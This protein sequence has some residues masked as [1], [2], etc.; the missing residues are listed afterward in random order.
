MLIDLEEAKTY[1]RVDSSNDTTLVL[2]LIPAAEKKVVD[3]ARLSAD[4]CQNICEANGNSVRIRGE[5]YSP[6]EIVMIYHL[7]RGAVLYALGYMY[8]HREEGDYHELELTLRSYLSSIR[9]GV[10]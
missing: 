6:S 7:L 5:E 1:L 4:E 10:I 2:N 3:V 8:E 9:E